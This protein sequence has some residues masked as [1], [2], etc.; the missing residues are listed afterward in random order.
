MVDGMKKL[1]EKYKRELMG[2]SRGSSYEK[3]SPLHFPEMI[4]FAP[5]E[6][7][8]DNKPTAQAVK[9]ETY[10]TTENPAMKPKPE[11]VTPI[12]E[13]VTNV[14][15]QGAPAPM[16][17]A[18]RTAVPAPQQSVLPSQTAF[19]TPRQTAPD[20]APQSPSSPNTA[21][22]NSVT[23][24]DFNAALSEPENNANNTPSGSNDI[25]DP[26]AESPD[27]LSETPVSGQSP[28]EQLGRRDFE[29]T[30]ETR[31]SRSDIQPLETQTNGAREML[32][33]R[34]YVDLRDYYNINN[35]RGTLRFRVYTAREALPVSGAKIDVTKVIGNDKHTFY[36]LT[37]DISGNTPIVYLPAPSSELSQQPEN[38]TQPYALYDVYITADNFRDVSIKNLPIFDG[39][40][41]EQSIAM[42]PMIAGG[43]PEQI[44]EYGPRVNGGV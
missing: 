22:E 2:Y 13:T 9:K 5:K 43:A 38:T 18:P 30:P 16:P 26:S 29:N 17:Q 36:K 31:N 25:R 40:L 6:G 21:P 3:P 7:S 27:R 14:P 44:T 1:V 11:P 41:S 19:P 23:R 32:P 35:R 10:V 33:E 28:D 34:E 37:T 12:R 42:I 20:N 39:I 8:A 24:V 4:A 15:A